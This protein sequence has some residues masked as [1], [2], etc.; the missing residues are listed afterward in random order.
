MKIEV[1]GEKRWILAYKNRKK[2]YPK[3]NTPKGGDAMTKQKLKTQIQQN[4]ATINNL[5]LSLKIWL[6]WLLIQGMFQTFGLNQGLIGLL[7]VAHLYG[8]SQLAKESEIAKFNQR[9]L[10]WLSVFLIFWYGK[11]LLFLYQTSA[12]LLTGSLSPT[13]LIGSLLPLGFEAFGL[14]QLKRAQKEKANP[15]TQQVLVNA[16]TGEILKEM[17]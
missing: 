3:S 4:L 9:L 7:Y 14:I 5:S 12:L 10:F 8:F 16:D 17:V 13:K 11:T 6:L 15:N 2:K 1:G